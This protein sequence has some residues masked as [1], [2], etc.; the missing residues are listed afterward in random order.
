MFPA[1]ALRN[2]GVDA[3]LPP[4]VELDTKQGEVSHLIN[5]TFGGDPSLAVST[6]LKIDADVYVFQQM[7]DELGVWMM[8]QLRRLGRLVVAESDDYYLG[9]PAYHSA[10]QGSAQQRNASRNRQW[11]LESFKAAEAMTVSTPFLAAEYGRLNRD[12]RVLPNY[13]N[14]E[15]WE[16][17]IPQYQVIRERKRVGWYGDMRM[18]AGDVR[19]IDGVIQPWLD[20]HPDWDFVA[21][22]ATHDYLRI[23]EDRRVVIEGVEFRSWRLPEIVACMDVGLVPLEMN[24][25]NEAKSHL[26]GMEY[27]ACGIPSVCSPT[28]PYRAYL[29]D[30][31]DGFLASRPQDWVR[32]LDALA[33]NDGLRREMGRAARRKARLNT[34]ERHAHEWVAVY[35]DLVENGRDRRLALECVNRYGAIQKPAELERLVGRVRELQPQRVLEVGSAKGGT[36]RAWTRLAAPDAT[37]VSVDLPGGRFGGGGITQEALEKMAQPGQTVRVIRGDSHDPVSLEAAREALGGPA[38]LLHID[39]DHTYSGVKADFEM[40]APLVREGGLVAFHDV[41]RHPRETGCEVDRLWREVKRGRKHREFVE[42]KKPGEPRWGGI[43]VLE[44]AA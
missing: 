33:E 44:V 15:M 30:G 32:A 1:A 28:G 23:P 12:V 11:I 10:L 3:A 18:R 17:V 36:L 31:V 7:A 5:L 39:G 14:W 21:T 20:R 13:L 34:I 24:G 16:H 41:V 25:F 38:D 43:G 29:E 40:Y 6:L 19:V 42:A 37:I 35:E 8:R 9:I 2:I 22:A 27:G 26:K 4:W